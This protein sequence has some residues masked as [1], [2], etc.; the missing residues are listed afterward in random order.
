MTCPCWALSDSGQS[1]SRLGTQQWCCHWSASPCQDTACMPPTPGTDSRTP[2][3]FV[4]LRFFEP[5]ICQQGRRLCC[6]K[7]AAASH[8]HNTHEKLRNSAP[9]SLISSKVLWQSRT[10]CALSAPMHKAGTYAATSLWAPDS[11]QKA[12]ATKPEHQTWASLLVMTLTCSLESSRTQ[13]RAWFGSYLLTISAARHIQKHGDM[14]SYA[15]QQTADW[16]MTCKALSTSIYWQWKS[17][18]VRSVHGC[19]GCHSHAFSV[20]CWMLEVRHAHD[21]GLWTAFSSLTCCPA[22]CNPG[23][24]LSISKKSCLLVL[25]LKRPSIFKALMWWTEHFCIMLSFGKPEWAAAWQS[26]L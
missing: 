17:T 16:H 14:L 23:S 24:M 9:Y 18:V 19:R 15:F 1:W 5:S 25:L 3:A 6:P 10:S 8:T 13:A 22:L 12:S 7:P 21:S 11:Q 26:Y 4:V 2:L 20:T